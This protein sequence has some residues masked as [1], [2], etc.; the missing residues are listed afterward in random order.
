MTLGA[1]YATLCDVRRDRFS[2]PGS[3]AAAA[4]LLAALLAWSAAC[5]AADF[6]PVPNAPL[7]SLVSALIVASTIVLVIGCVLLHYE[8]LRLLSYVLLRF[9]AKR[10][11]RILMLVLALVALATVEIWLFGLG[12]YWLLSSPGYGALHGPGRVDE[13]LDYVYFSA[14][15]YTTLGLGDLVPSGSIRFLVG[16]QALVGFTLISWSAAFTFLEMERFWRDS[17]ERRHRAAYGP[18]RD[19]A[20][21]G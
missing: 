2:L 13:F 11:R 7:L 1:R 17:T 14:V 9:H 3:A 8:T 21:G 5:A 16:T 12:Y 18:G 10:R 15:I 6:V 19:H 20:D 4:A